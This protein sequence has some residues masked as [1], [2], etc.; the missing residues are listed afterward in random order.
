VSSIGLY[1][2]RQIE[3][4]IDV[5]SIQSEGEMAIVSE[6]GK[7]RTIT[8]TGSHVRSFHELIEELV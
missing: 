8:K 5:G 4:R 6:S 7:N 1:P 3:E 2:K